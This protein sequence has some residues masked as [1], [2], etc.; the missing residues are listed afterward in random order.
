MGCPSCGHQVGATAKFC[1][2]CGERLGGA[3]R[4]VG[5]AVGTVPC[6]ELRA[7]APGREGPDVAGRAVGEP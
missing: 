1:L 3:P 4:S 2:A 7:E 5:H 6:A